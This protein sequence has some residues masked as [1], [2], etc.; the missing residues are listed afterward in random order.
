MLE[1]RGLSPTIAGGI[2]GLCGKLISFPLDTVKKKIQGH[3]LF[4]SPQDSN[5][6]VDEPF[7][8]IE[9]MRTLFGDS[10]S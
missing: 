1:S 7:D 3:S 9:L 5:R 2:A 8:A 10:N 4:M 6:Q